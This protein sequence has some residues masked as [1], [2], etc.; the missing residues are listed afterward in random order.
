MWFFPR[1]LGF[2]VNYCVLCCY[3]FYVTTMITLFM[4]TLLSSPG[5][6]RGG[7][8]LCAVFIYFSTFI[9]NN[10]FNI[11]H[12]HIIIISSSALL[13]SSLHRKHNN[14]VHRIFTWKPKSWGENHRSLF[15]IVFP[16]ITRR[17]QQPPNYKDSNFLTSTG[18]RLRTP[19]LKASN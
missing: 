2:H 13:S 11:M 14:T 8:N 4:K 1:D 3:S 7:V 17:R 9:I 12:Y 19:D 5:T 10:L 18:R 15:K 6:Q 16:E